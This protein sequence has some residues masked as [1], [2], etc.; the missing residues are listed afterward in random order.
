MY[1]AIEK[2]DITASNQEGSNK[3]SFL[4]IHIYFQARV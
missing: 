4:I 1:P 2:Q 3:R